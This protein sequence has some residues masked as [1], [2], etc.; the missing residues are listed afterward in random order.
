MMSAR[1]SGTGAWWPARKASRD[2]AAW[3][4]FGKRR[5]RRAA[6]SWQAAQAPA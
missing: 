4:V 1:V 2:A 3:S 6:E 5:A